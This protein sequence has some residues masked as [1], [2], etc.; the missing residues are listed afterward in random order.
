MC[1][2][3]IIYNAFCSSDYIARA[4]EALFYKY[5][6]ASGFANERYRMKEKW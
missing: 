2:R 6:C 5:K 3:Y 1:Y 4:R